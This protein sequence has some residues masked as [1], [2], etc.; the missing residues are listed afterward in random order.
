MKNIFTKHPNKIGESYVQ[1]FFKACMFSIKLVL[2]SV[3]VFIHAIFPFL[4]ENSAS[5]SINKINNILQ[6]R[7]QSNSDNL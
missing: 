6:K 1:H 4:F 2:I 7:A 5:D 3:K